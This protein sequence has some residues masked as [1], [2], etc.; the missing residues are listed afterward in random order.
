[1]KCAITRHPATRVPLFALLLT[2]FFGATA[3]AGP[4][5]V[6]PLN[7]KTGLWQTTMVTTTSGAPPMT[8]D[9]EARLAQMPPEQRAKIEA[10][11]KSRLG[12]TP[13][14]NTYKSCITKED[15]NKYPFSDPKQN[16]SYNVLTS[17]GSK[18][19][20]SGTCTEN[21]GM[22]TNFTMRLQALDSENVTG[23]GQVAISGGGHTMN[24]NYTGTGKWLS[25]SCPA[26]MK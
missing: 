4:G 8:P 19:D 21:N 12:G 2:S 10:M 3:L 17:T 13:Q 1:M 5:N 6:Q 18:M 23:T 20:V 26:G 25:P 9:M 11:M 15:L 24:G 22:K 16:C 14:T 7:V